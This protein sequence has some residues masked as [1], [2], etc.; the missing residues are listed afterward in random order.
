M[1]TFLPLEGAS[2]TRKKVFEIAASLVKQNSAARETAVFSKTL[3]PCSAT[4]WP[5]APLTQSGDK[6]GGLIIP[7]FLS[8]DEG[9]W[10]NEVRY[11]F[12]R[13]SA[14]N[15]V[16]ELTRTEFQKF[17]E[18]AEEFLS[19]LRTVEGRVVVFGEHL[20]KSPDPVV[21]KETEEQRVVFQVDPPF[22]QKRDQQTYCPTVSLRV[23]N[24]KKVGT[25]TG[26]GGGGG[27]VDNWKDAIFPQLL[28]GG[29]SLWF[30]VNGMLAFVIR[31]H[32]CE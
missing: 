17:L 18:V 29:S 30:F 12:F 7:P 8:S 13:P 6:F 16:V 32:I 2:S 24:R 26:I 11:V 15:A 28:M 5:I 20:P 23:Q 27:P 14:M 9:E 25:W 31:K 21:L 1:K 19:F 10:V 4:I 3:S 22:R